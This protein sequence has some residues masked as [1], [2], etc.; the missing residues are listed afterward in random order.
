MKKLTLIFA[1][2]AGIV[3]LLLTSQLWPDTPS[4]TSQLGLPE[5]QSEKFGL[6]STAA[7]HPDLFSQY[8]HD[9]RASSDGTN[10]YAVGYRIRE[11]DKAIAAAKTSGTRLNWVE[12]GPGNVGGRT[13]ALLVDPDDPNR[14]TWWAGSVSGGLWKTTDGGNRWRS[15]TDHLPNLSVTCLAMAASNPDVIYMGTG[16]GTAGAGAVT[17]DGIF[18][19]NDRGQTWT[20]LTATTANYNFRYVNR[21]V[22]DPSNPDV[23]LAAANAGIFRTTDGGKNW[24]H[25]WDPAL[26]ERGGSVQ[27][28]RAQPGN[29]AMQIAAVNGQGVLFSTNAGLDWSYA[30]SDFVDSPR[31]IEL[32]YSPSH[33]NVAYAAAEGATGAQLYRSDNGGANWSPTS[34]PNDFNWMGGQGWF[35]NTLAVHPFN[36]D[37]VFVGG[38]QLWR[39][40]LSGGKT[41]IGL[42]G[43]LDTGGTESWI[44]WLSLHG[45][46][47][48]GRASY[49]HHNALDVTDSDYANIEIL[50]GFGTQKA[51]RFWVSQTAGFYGTGG[52][53]VNFSEYRYGGYVDVPF[54]VWDVDNERQLM[55]SFRDQANDGEFNLIEYF[56]DN[57]NPGTRDLQSFEFIFIH[58]YD[59][60]PASPHATIAASG[61]VV[62]GMLYQLW[63]VLASGATWDPASLPSQTVGLE[64][65]QVDSYVRSIDKGLDPNN[66]VHVD[67]HG[68]F[69]IPV[70]Q[71]QND[72][73]ILSASDGGVAVSRDNGNTFLE[74]DDP[75]SGYNT[76]QVYG[77]AKAPGSAFYIAGFQDNGTFRSYH[78]PNSGRG[79]QSS[80]G[81]DGIETI[82]HATDPNRI[83]ATTQYS[84]VLRSA[85]GGVSWQVVLPFDPSQG[86]FVTSIDSGDLAPDNVYSTKRDGIWISRDF[87]QTWSL[88]PVTEAWAPWDGCKVRVSIANADVVWAGCGLVAGSEKS[89]LHLSRDHGHLFEPTALPTIPEAPNSV[90]SGLATH[91][92][93]PGTAYALFSARGRP[94]ILETKD[95]GQ[96]WMDLSGFI[97]GA[98]MNGFPDVA[99]YDLVVMPH[100]TNVL[101]A[102]TEIGLFVSRNSGVDWSYSD[103]GLPAVSV[104]RMKIRDNELIVGTHGRGVW[105]VPVSEVDVATEELATELPS[106]FSLRQNYP[107]PFN[108]STT[109]EFGVREES[110]VRLVVFDGVGR[111]VSVLTDQVHTPGTHKLR[112]NAE[113]FSSGVYLYRMES[114]GRLVHVRKMTLVK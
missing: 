59:Y 109:I 28:L 2:L 105:T 70:D 21:L 22:V 37:I 13:R 84:S 112:W 69:P 42:P 54:Q 83:L 20:H 81:A 63:P 5:V 29:F 24:T 107:N 91:P 114:D 17:G 44:D 4:P 15:V 3:L 102:G 65:R 99:V 16:E 39:T 77:V 53:D 60:D 30:R 95:Y 92:I 110:H 86:Q 89:T 45:S 25:V 71:N 75:F 66:T 100:A 52:A 49:L 33:P 96:T 108:A 9:I 35:D 68:I 38:I 32:A 90:I 72:F 51:H 56:R 111:K 88:Y 40:V 82:W 48:E 46:A 73:W 74:T 14:N 80:V 67:H 85:D 104:W 55:V 106:G 64:F 6:G 23:V 76:S 10:E 18:K 103:N 62:N 36:P 47:F 50:F 11:F 31:R 58:K 27:D 61:G 113:A 57:T 12:R 101:W 93:E 98:S 78:D 87:G 94:K 34:E 8:H 19:S 41:T 97:S 1:I 79:W 43:D 26:E 7:G